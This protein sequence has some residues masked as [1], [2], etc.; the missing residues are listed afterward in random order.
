MLYTMYYFCMVRT[1]PA[2]N[3]IG[4]VEAGS[5]SLRENND[6]IVHFSEFQKSSINNVISAIEF[7]E[8]NRMH[9]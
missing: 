3:L 4:W 8:Q 5:Q 6:Q 7:S 9:T 2:A 1:I